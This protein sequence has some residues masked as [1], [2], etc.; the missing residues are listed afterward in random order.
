MGGGS[1]PGVSD[2]IAR[3]S[4]LVF[5]HYLANIVYRWYQDIIMI[6]YTIFWKDK[7]AEKIATRIKKKHKNLLFFWSS[8]TL[9]VVGA[10]LE[11]KKIDLWHFSR[12]SM[13]RESQY[14]GSTFE[15]FFIKNIFSVS[16][17]HPLQRKYKVLVDS[18]T[19]IRYIYET[20]KSRKTGWYLN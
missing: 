20:I 6:F 1:R 2:I 10:V 8:K 12:E 7:N 14:I 5:S 17:K 16:R 13:S 3:I 11:I 9:R 19:N 4:Y 18:L 15:D